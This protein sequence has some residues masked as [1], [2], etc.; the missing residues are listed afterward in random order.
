MTAVT[1]ELERLQF[2]TELRKNPQEYSA[3]VNT[4]IDQMV[5]EISETKTDA[6]KKAQIDLGRYMDMDHNANFYKVRNS[7]VDRLTKSVSDNNSSIAQGLAQDKQISKRQFEI[8]EWYNQNKLETLFF[9]QMFFVTSLGMI[10]LLSLVKAGY[11]PVL[12]AAIGSAVIGFGVV[13]TGIYRYYYTD[14]TRDV[15]LWNRRKFGQTAAPV[16]VPEDRCPPADEEEEDDTYMN[17]IAEGVGSCAA[18]YGQAARK[19][20]DEN[21][22]ALMDIGST[23]NQESINAVRTGKIDVDW[24]GALN[25]VCPGSFDLSETTPMTISF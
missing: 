20:L 13:F 11:I 7:D 14:Q 25:K 8:N 3:Y 1:Q 21:G 22:Q 17:E 15:R 2:S 23:L 9:L 16:A 18:G 10:L 19:T 6:F 12:L 24:Q 4:R 5:G